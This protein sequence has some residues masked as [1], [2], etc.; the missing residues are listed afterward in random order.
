MMSARTNS[1]ETVNNYFDIFFFSFPHHILESSFTSKHFTW[2]VSVSNRKCWGVFFSHHTASFVINILC[3]PLNWTVISLK[4]AHKIKNRNSGFLISRQ[5]LFDVLKRTS[6]LESL[7]FV[8]NFS[9]LIV[10]LHLMNSLILNTLCLD[11]VSSLGYHLVNIVRII[12]KLILLVTERCR[13]LEWE[14]VHNWR[15]SQ[16]NRTQFS[17]F[18]HLHQSPIVETAFPKLTDVYENLRLFRVSGNNISLI[19]F[20]P[21][22]HCFM[23][24]GKRW[25]GW[26]SQKYL[27]ALP[28]KI[29][30]FYG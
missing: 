11:Y 26:K 9:I 15:F 29:W 25:R 24:R 23:N 12:I 22:Q 6:F 3:C 16:E 20:M 18:T 5:R 21:G 19:Y 2:T 10:Y 13:P 14:S 8:I 1:S 17:S 28:V 7:S 4:N 27:C 30:N